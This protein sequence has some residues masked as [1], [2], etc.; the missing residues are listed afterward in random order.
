MIRSSEGQRATLTCLYCP[1][2][3]VLAVTWERTPEEVSVLSQ[4]SGDRS[5][6][7]RNSIVSQT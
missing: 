1:P 7:S 4:P 2:R 6:K 3:T 5:I